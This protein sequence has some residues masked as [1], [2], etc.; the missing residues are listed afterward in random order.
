ML[1]EFPL[2]LFPAPTVTVKVPLV[3]NAFVS[4]K[5][6]PAPPPPFIV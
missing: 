3:K 4:Y 2:A 6:P 1:L 5:T